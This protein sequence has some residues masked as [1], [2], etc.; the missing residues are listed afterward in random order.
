MI[1]FPFEIVF[2]SILFISRSI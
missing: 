2:F 1:I